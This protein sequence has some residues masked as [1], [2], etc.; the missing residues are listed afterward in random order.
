MAKDDPNYDT[1]AKRINSDIRYGTGAASVNIY[2]G[3]IHAVFG[4]SNTKGN[5]RISAV[6]LLD[7]QE[8]CHFNIDEAYGGGK[9][10]PMDAEAQLHMACIPG[11]KTAYGGAQDADIQGNV[12]LN[13]TNGN[14][15]RVFGG[16]N[17][18]GTI[19]G[20]ITVNIEEI[21]CKPIIIGQLY[22]GGNL[23]PYTAP[24]GKDGPTVN[25]KSFT[26]IG[27]VY[28]GGYGA[29]AIVTGDTYVNI[30]E[31]LGDKAS[32]EQFMKTKVTT[33]T[34]PATET[35]GNDKVSMNTG[36]TKTFKDGN[37]AN[38]NTISVE[39]PL[40]TSG[41]I[42]VINNVF[43]GGNAAE[44]NGNTYVKIGTQDKVYVVKSITSGTS[45]TQ[46]DRYY[47][48]NDDGTYTQATGTAASG[49][50][51][52]EEKDVVG[53]DIRG[54][55]Y[56]GGNNAE[57]TGNTNVTIGKESTTTTSPAPENT[58]PNVIPEP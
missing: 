24:D 28:G 9:S 13:I 3:N 17:I 20:T 45:F 8:G 14:F 6:T 51:Y 34:D 43:G 58:T 11:L 5:V 1:K 2:G 19:S 42:G 4:G 41:K 15:D 56:G 27:E 57:V 25:V 49:T 12:T 33:V 46:T 16:N 26:S 48:R 40:H 23:A 21:G 50:T 39:I 54:N 7:D 22:G 55:V 35:I 44:V 30:D 53:V 52:Y 29:G 47:T 18:S 38:A 10:A 36:V 31:V 32:T 37:G